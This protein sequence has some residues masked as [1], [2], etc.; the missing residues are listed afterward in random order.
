MPWASGGQE[1]SDPGED[2]GG[3]ERSDP[4]EDTG[5]TSTPPRARWWWRV[6]DANNRCSLRLRRSASGSIQHITG[7]SKKARPNVTDM[8][9]MSARVAGRACT[10]FTDQR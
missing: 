4:G 8:A 2:T 3:Q 7:S 1:R 5:A 6:S 10:L 9:L